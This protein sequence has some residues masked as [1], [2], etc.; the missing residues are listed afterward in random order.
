MT[1]I[2][3]CD[4]VGFGSSGLFTLLCERFS[5]NP[6]LPPSHSWIFGLADGT[7]SIRSDSF[8]MVGLLQDDQAASLSIA[9]AHIAPSNG[10]FFH[11]LPWQMIRRPNRSAPFS[12]GAYGSPRS[13]RLLLCDTLKAHIVG[14]AA[15]PRSQGRFQPSVS[16]QLPTGQTEVAPV[17]FSSEPLSSLACAFIF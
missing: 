2:E 17:Q 5:A 8:L 13:S 11:W 1:S 14:K 12:T 9:Q 7:R 6:S 10:P 16:S 4:A 3:R 15:V